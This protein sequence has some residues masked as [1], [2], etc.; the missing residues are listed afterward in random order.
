MLP[1]GFTPKG[2]QRKGLANTE[3]ESLTDKGKQDASLSME[4]KMPDS[5]NSDAEEVVA[6]D[7]DN[8]DLDVKPVA[9]EVAVSYLYDF[10]WDKSEE[11][12]E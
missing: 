6:E 11:C 2:Y 7:E 9:E 4:D 12:F 5:S 3:S 10:Y 8:Y 1:P